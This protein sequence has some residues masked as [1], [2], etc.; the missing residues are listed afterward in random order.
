MRC[1]ICKDALW[2][3]VVVRDKITG[4]PK[5]RVALCQCR[6]AQERLENLQQQG[7]KVRCYFTLPMD[8]IVPTARSWDEIIKFTRKREAYLQAAIGEEPEDEGGAP[9]YDEE[10]PF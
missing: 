5:Y 10:L 4:E 2:L 6:P 7:M 8:I 1:E 9:D 3:P